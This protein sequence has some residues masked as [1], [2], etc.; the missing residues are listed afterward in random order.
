MVIEKSDNPIST[1][2]EATKRNAPFQH[3]VVTLKLPNSSSS[4][5]ISR[6]KF[7]YFSSSLTALLKYPSNLSSFV[8][9]I[10]FY[11]RQTKIVRVK[12]LMTPLGWLRVNVWIFTLIVT[13]RKTFPFRSFLLS[14][15]VKLDNK[16]TTAV[17]DFNC[18]FGYHLTKSEMTVLFP[19]TEYHS[20]RTGSPGHITNISVSYNKLNG[21]PGGL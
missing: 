2:P 5:T 10:E 11:S 13:A 14:C 15:R 7:R 3:L 12:T 6:V 21:F 4:V 18:F 19:S 9:N 20:R 17:R 16:S 8:A 1:S